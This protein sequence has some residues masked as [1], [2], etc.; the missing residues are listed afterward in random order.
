MDLTWLGY[1]ATR[2]RTRNAAVVM[3]PYDKTVGGTMGRP[4]AHI[5]TSSHD[6]SMRNGVAAVAPADGD[7]MHLVGPGEYEIRGVQVEG[8]R[9]SLRGEGD[10]AARISTL[11]LLEAELLRVAHLG[12]LGAALTAA[13]LD[14]LSRA[15]IAIVPIA[16]ADTL[17][18]EDA[19]KAIRAMEPSIVIPVG[20]DPADDA[21]LKAFVRALGG[22][23][24][25]PVGR[26]TINSRSFD[27]ETR[28]IVLLEPRA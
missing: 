28:R 22:T 11:W 13:Q 19:A 23:A 27:G 6:D 20:Y 12:G 14:V 10:P 1:A 21:P 7:P 2:M 26:F 8:V 25:E 18:P 15:D 5:I 17:G 9:G 4:D 24:E 3:D 16:L